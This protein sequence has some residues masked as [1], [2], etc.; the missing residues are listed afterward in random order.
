M[1]KDGERWCPRCNGYK[2][3][4]EFGAMPSYIDGIDPYCKEHRKEARDAS[5]AKS[6]RRAEF[7]HDVSKMSDAEF[8]RFLIW[9][10][11]EAG[12]E[13]AARRLN[14]GDYFAPD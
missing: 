2:D 12:E 5:R 11:K 1:P 13:E 14:G 6:R 10:L 4:S 8:G 7:D 3:V 9:L